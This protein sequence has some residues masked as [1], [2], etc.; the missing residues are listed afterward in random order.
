MAELQQEAYPVFTAGPGRQTV[1]YD[2]DSITVRLNSFILQ[3]SAI[4]AKFLFEFHRAAG[5]GVECLQCLL[6]VYNEFHR[7]PEKQTWG[8]RLSAFNL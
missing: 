5:E 4:T 6:N 1:T 2:G 3:R 8:F 7:N